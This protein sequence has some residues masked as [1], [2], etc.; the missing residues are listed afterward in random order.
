MHREPLGSDG[1]G[2]KVRAGLKVGDVDPRGDPSACWEISDKALAVG[3]GVMEAVMARP[4]GA[5]DPPSWC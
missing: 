1:L 5:I 2:M 3:G 4:G